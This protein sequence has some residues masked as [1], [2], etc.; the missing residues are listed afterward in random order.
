M[1]EKRKEATLTL[2]RA[3]N[4]LGGRGRHQEIAEKTG[5][6]LPATE[7]L[8]ASSLSKGLVAVETSRKKI[9]Q[10]SEEGRSYAKRDLPE[11]RL[12][13]A[14][15]ELGGE[16]SFDK[17]VEKAFG[18]RDEA[19]ELPDYPDSEARLPHMHNVALGWMVR[20]GWCEKEKIED[21]LNLKVKISPN[22]GE[23]ERLLRKILNLEDHG[24]KLLREDLSSVEEKA[25]QT[26]IKRGLVVEEEEVSQDF[27]LTPKGSELLKGGVE[28][29]SALTS[30]L[31]SSGR[32]REVRLR[33]YNVTAPPPVLYPG[34][35]HFYVEFLEEVRRLLVSLGFEEAEGPYVEM[36]FWNFDLL[37]QAQ[38]HPAR[39]I[40]DSYLVKGPWKGALTESELVEAV[41][42]VHE[43]GGG[44]GSRGWRYKWDIEVAKRLLLRTQTTA[45]SMRHLASHKEPPVKMFCLS[46][47]F[48][49]DVLDARHAIEFS[50]CEGI[51]MDRG[52]NFRHLLGFLQEFAEALDL[53]EVRFRPGYFPFTEPSVE[54]FVKH[55]TLGWVE[56]MG[57]GLFRPEVLKPL[58]V[59]HPVLAWGIGIDRIAMAKLGVDDIRDL[60]SKR[61]E[62]LREA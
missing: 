11:R 10:L 59:E 57:A 27:R 41:R 2:L 6:S 43:D 56:V 26:L 16:A 30:D 50:Q 13:K 62:Y 5:F 49:P 7:T 4:D 12:A 22:E 60:F 32:W 53:G 18:F 29:V 47:V 20:K 54:T 44:T 9:I 37:F 23:D 46:R 35:K 19:K 52:L 31:I 38:D 21:T 36:E 40:H 25:A 55:P 3:L 48:R 51:V 39:E 61:L 28:E 34:K 42:G 24:E 45:V 15:L 1:T 58:K 17:A 14:V 33:K 8:I